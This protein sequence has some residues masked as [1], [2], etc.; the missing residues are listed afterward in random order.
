MSDNLSTHSNEIIVGM[1][2]LID[3]NHKVENKCAG[4]FVT[5]HGKFF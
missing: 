2:I 1:S 3:L 5:V 4:D